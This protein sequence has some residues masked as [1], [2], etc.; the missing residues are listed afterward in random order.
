MFSTGHSPFFC[1]EKTAVAVPA[2]AAAASS[3]SVCAVRRG[4]CKKAD[5]SPSAFFMIKVLPIF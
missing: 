2:A 5:G 3:L 1:L 4:R